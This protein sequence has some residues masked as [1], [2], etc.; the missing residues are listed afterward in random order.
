MADRRYTI[1][2][3]TVNLEPPPTLADSGLPGHELSFVAG[4]ERN[5]ETLLALFEEFDVRSTFFVNDAVTTAAPTL[6]RRISEQGHE[7]AILS[8]R[9]ANPLDQLLHFREEIASAKQRLEEVVGESVCGFRFVPVTRK[10]RSPSMLETLVQEGFVYSSSSFPRQTLTPLLLSSVKRAHRVNTDSGVLWE[11]PLTCWRPFG[12]GIP[13]IPTAGG[14]Y[15]SILPGWTIVRGVEGMNRHGEPALLH[16]H[17]CGLD[18]LPTDL[19]PVP[20]WE[21]LLTYGPQ[22]VTIAKLRRVFGIYRFA[23]IMEAYAS[24]L[25]TDVTRNRPARRTSIIRNDAE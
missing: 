16:V 13:S 6:V 14:A 23:S 2:A 21:R 9:F 5:A 22:E 1:N 12:L 18:H 8:R 11:I 10:W 25:T 24:R 4:V 17:S 3:F 7:L 15:L 20:L 19:A